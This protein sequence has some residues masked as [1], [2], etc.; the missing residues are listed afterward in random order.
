MGDEN[1]PRAGDRPGL[2]QVLDLECRVWDALVAGDPEADGAMLTPEFLGVYPDGFSDR[3]SHMAQLRDGPV[4]RRYALDQARLTGIGP[5]HV[6]LSYRA[7]F[8]RADAA[9]P[10]VMFISSLWQ[11]TPRGWLNSLSQDTPAA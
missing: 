6:L 7:T 10:E 3:A 4:M 8:V 9:E 5:Y 2:Q 11:R 1:N